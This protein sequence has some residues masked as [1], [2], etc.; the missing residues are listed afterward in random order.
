MRRLI[1]LVLAALLAAIATAH[2]VR[3]DGVEPTRRYDAP[4]HRRHVVSHGQARPMPAM[5]VRG[6]FGSPLR[7]YREGPPAPGYYGMSH[8]AG[9]M[10]VEWREP[11]IDRR[12]VYNL[13]PEP[14]W[15]RGYAYG[16]RGGFIRARY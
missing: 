8:V 10:L 4:A 12:L 3:A 9:P 16:H 15:A 13:P 6:R 7:G 5:H 14:V 2:Q 11:Y 1:S